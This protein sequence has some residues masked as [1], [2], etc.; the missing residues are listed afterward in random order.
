[1]VAYESLLQSAK[2]QLMIGTRKVGVHSS[3]QKK[4][5]AFISRKISACKKHELTGGLK[6]I[7][8]LNRRRSEEGG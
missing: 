8:I 6:G 4:T 1:L 7:S 3:L 5:T 2:E